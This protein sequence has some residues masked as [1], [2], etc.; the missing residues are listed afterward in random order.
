[1]EL[2]ESKYKLGDFEKLG[3]DIKRDLIQE[4]LESVGHNLIVTPK[5]VDTFVSGI[6]TIVANGQN[7]ALHKAVNPTNISAHLK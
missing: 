5:E 6:A 1:M 4:I 7:M 2:L 3:P